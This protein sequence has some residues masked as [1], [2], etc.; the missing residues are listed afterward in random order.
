MALFVLLF[1]VNAFGSDVTRS[2]D[3]TDGE[4]LTAAQLD[5]AFDEI[6]T[7]CNDIDGDQLASDIAIVTTGLCRFGN[8]VAFT[9]SDNLEYIDSLADGYLDL[10][11]TT[12]LR[13]RINT[14]EQIN[15]IDGILQPTTDN[16]IDLGA[17]AKEYKN[18]YIDGTGNIDSCV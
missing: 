11:A 15:L 3:F 7:E 16:D 14:T 4:I 6:I 2:H 10:E 1:T 17:A 18:L 5:T 9:Q 13:L 8:K 12:G